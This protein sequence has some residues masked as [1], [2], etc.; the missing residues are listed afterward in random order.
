MSDSRMCPKCNHTEI[1]PDHFCV[2]CGTA[3]IPVP[4]CGKCSQEMW[5]Y[6]DYCKRCALPRAEAIAYKPLPEQKRGFWT[7]LF[8]L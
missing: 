5:P 6:M 3:L 7:R 1:I 4:E 8:G 2:M